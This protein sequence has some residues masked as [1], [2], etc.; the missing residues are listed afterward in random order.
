M[1][2]GDEIRKV[3]AIRNCRIKHEVEVAS[4]T[5]TKSQEKMIEQGWRR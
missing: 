4:A 5:T 1:T 2:N 3:W